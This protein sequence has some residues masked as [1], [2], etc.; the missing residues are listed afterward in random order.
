[1]TTDATPRP[2]ARGRVP[3]HIVPLSPAL[4]DAF[5]ELWV[6]WLRAT[7]GKEPEPEDRVAVHD[8]HGFYIVPGGAVFFAVAG[9][10]PVGVV[11]VKQLTPG[12]YEFCKLV[13]LDDA[14]G[15]GVGRALVERCIDFARDAGGE[16]LMLQSIRR[17]RVALDMYRRM[18]FVEMPPPAAMQVLE[19][20]EVV[21]GMRLR[22]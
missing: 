9:G 8:P 20:T 18:G 19:R 17:L 16:W 6:P 14:R 22:D 7:T 3:S 2:G 1:M 13:V 21:M 11:A 12:T 4:R 10:R 15:M 5:A